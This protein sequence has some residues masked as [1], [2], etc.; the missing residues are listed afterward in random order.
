MYMVDELNAMWHAV[1]GDLY[2]PAGQPFC[3][4]GQYKKRKREG[5]RE[6]GGIGKARYAGAKPS[7]KI[8]ADDLNPFPPRLGCGRPPTCTQPRHLDWLMPTT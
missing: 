4:S 1:Y 6:A 3:L 7:P 2:R 8:N 5:K